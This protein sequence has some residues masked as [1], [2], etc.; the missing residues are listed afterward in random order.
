MP[1][2]MTTVRIN[3]IDYTLPEL[4][5]D[6]WKQLVSAPARAQNGGGSGFKTM[7]LATRTLDQ[8]VDARTVVLRQADETAR[9]LW[10]HTD[11][12]AAKVMQLEA[13]PDVVLLF[14]DEKRQVQ[15][16]LR[17][18][19]TVHIDDAVADAQWKN[20]RVSSRKMYLSEQTPGTQQPVPYPGFPAA[21][22]ENLPT[23]AESEAGRPNFAAV[24][25]QI[26]EME[27]LHL[28]RKGQARAWF[29]YAPEP[30]FSWLA[31]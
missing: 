25:C 9:L 1:I 3:D 6:C 2:N 31:P 29:R 21:L 14:W 11:V 26:L 12:R 28:S 22:G 19:T 27:Y 15:L 17:A 18:E 5:R 30:T 4:D 23:E 24:A 10:F 13:F 20:L 16:R 7:T 8:G